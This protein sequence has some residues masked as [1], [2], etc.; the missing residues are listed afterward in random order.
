M[1]TTVNLSPDT[2]QDLKEYIK[3][4]KTKKRVYKVSDVFDESL[5]IALPILKDRFPRKGESE[6][7]FYIRRIKELRGYLKIL[8]GQM[9]IMI[10]RELCNLR[11]DAFSKGYIKFIE[12]EENI[13]IMKGEL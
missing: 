6:R 5:R 9:S 1:R 8:S 12:S 7:H 13:S 2:L 3:L 4:V 11:V 10:L